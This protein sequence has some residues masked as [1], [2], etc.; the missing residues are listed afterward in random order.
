VVNQL[1]TSAASLP[2]IIEQ[3]AEPEM[4]G[5]LLVLTKRDV[6]LQD[7]VPFANV[8]RPLVATE[9]TEGQVRGEAWRT[10]ALLGLVFLSGLALRIVWWHFGPKVIESE[11]IGYARVAENI[12]ACLG[13]SR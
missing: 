8:A 6:L 5:E 4:R 11:G 9:E 10:W 1:S 2:D 12:A 3:N 13:A 7:A